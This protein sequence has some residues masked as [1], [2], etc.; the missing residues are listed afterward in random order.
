MP[1]KLNIPL[2]K[3]K[4]NTGL[5]ENGMDEREKLKIEWNSSIKL[6]KKNV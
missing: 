5:E 3:E 1:Q 6:Y 4:E 2:K